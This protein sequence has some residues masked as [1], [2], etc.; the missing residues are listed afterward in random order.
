MNKKHLIILSLICLLGFLLRIFLITQIP[1]SISADEAAYGYNAYSIL[2]TGKDEFK[3]TLPLLFR[4]FDDHKNPL[5]VYLLVPFIYFFGLNELVIRLPSVIIGSLTII[6]FFFLTK[7][8]V[9]NGK[10][11][12][13]VAFF[14]SISAWLIQYSRVAIEMETALFLSLLGVWLFLEGRKHWL[15]YFLSNLFFGLAFWT[16]NANKLWVLL[17][18]PLL[19]LINNKFSKAIVLAGFV[20]IIFVIPNIKLYFSSNIMFRSYGISVFS[21]EQDKYKAADL[22]LQDIQNKITGSKIVHNRRLIPFNQFSEGFLRAINPGIL[23]ST[24]INN[25]NP[26]TRLF[27]LWQMPLLVIGFL[28][29]FQNK[30]RFLLLFLW[31]F[32]G[33]IPSAITFL[34]PFD[35][36]MLI[37][38][39]PLIFLIGSGLMSILFSFNK[40]RFPIF[41][42]IFASLCILV[43]SISFYFY[44]HIYFLHGKNQVV[45]LWGNGMKELVLQTIKEKDKYDSVIVSIEIG[46]AHV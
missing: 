33:L 27:Y 46:R 42:N 15:Y 12:L 18:I 30:K 24:D 22:I 9:K 6:L 31:I 2:K 10:T 16:Y 1:N 5:F 44:L 25:Q 13:L 36:R 37:I 8:L 40:I 19:L 3:V 20:F 39:Y 7:S 35:R 38:S 45:Q 23:F 34:P 26:A 21:N 32:T 11:A 41:K 43:I 29:E 28:F 17:F 4:S 14:S